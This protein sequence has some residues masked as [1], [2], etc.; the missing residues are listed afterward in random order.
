MRSESKMAIKKRSMTYSVVF[1][2]RRG[3]R[4]VFGGRLL[5]GEGR[6]GVLNPKQ[7]YPNPSL[8][9]PFERMN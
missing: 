7:K 9:V 3:V 8:G 1:F 6:I 4:V 5:G 2:L